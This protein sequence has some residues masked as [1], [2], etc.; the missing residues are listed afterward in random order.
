MYHATIAAAVRRFPLL[1]RPRPDCPALPLRIQEITDAANAAAQKGEHGVADAAHVLNKAALIASDAG[2][3]E[4]ARQLC[5]QH[6]NAYRRLTRPLTTLEAHYMLEPVLNLARLQ[7]RADQGT[8][9][10]RLIEAMYEAVTRHTD[11]TIGEHTLPTANLTGDR[12]DRRK[13]REWVWLQLVGEGIR[14]LALGNRWGDAADHARIHN[15]IGD[16]LLE[17]RQAVIVA[18]CVQGDP[19]QGRRVLAASA[20]TEPWEQQVAACLDLICAGPGSP[21][22]VRHLATAVERLA[23]PMTAT[24]YASYRTRLGLTVAILA[25]AV[26]PE[27]ATQVLH[28]TAQQAIETADGYAARDVLGFREPSAGITRDQYVDL[29]RIAAEA[30][31]GVGEL[32]AAVVC[33]MTT[34]AAVAVE[35]LDTALA[36]V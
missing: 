14:I 12:D 21:R 6:I 11:L 31:L 36:P 13:L 17:G 1:G 23:L 30:G 24:N 20:L 29:R 8:S 19:D 28:E 5:W 2:M 34:T 25:G 10:L 15:G 9:A 18:S 26:E 22:A 27:V 35:A 16:H 3:P 32:P 7:I 4:F 33:E